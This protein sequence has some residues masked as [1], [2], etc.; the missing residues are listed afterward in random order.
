MESGDPRTSWAA[1][2]VLSAWI[3]AA[4]S[5]GGGLAVLYL[6]QGG[7]VALDAGRLASGL[8]QTWVNPRDG[9]RLEGPELPPE[10]QLQAPDGQDW[11]LILR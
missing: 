11:L 2:D 7:T 9:S 6:P 3:V 8:R 5:E 1:G 10:G 4:R